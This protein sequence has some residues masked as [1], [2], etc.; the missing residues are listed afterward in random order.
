MLQND[1]EDSWKALSGQ[2][3]FCELRNIKSELWFK[4]KKKAEGGKNSKLSRLQMSMS[5]YPG[6]KGKVCTG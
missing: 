2:E 5:K 4:K 6:K 3:K 1:K